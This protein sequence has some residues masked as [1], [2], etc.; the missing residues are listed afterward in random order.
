M[1]KILACLSVILFYGF[2]F[3]QDPAAFDYFKEGDAALNRQQYAQALAYF[4]NAIETDG[5][6]PVYLNAKSLA[7]TSM[8]DYNGAIELNT[9]ALELAPENIPTLISR[10]VNYVLVGQF[11]K[12]RADLD[13]A[14]PY[15]S[16][17]P[18]YYVALGIFN[19]ALNNDSQAKQNY[20]QAKKLGI[21]ETET[22]YSRL[23]VLR[24]IGQRTKALSGYNELI[25][26]NRNDINAYL[27]RAR[28]QSQLG[29]IDN[30]ISDYNYVLAVSSA[31]CDA[32]TWK[33]KLSNKPSLTAEERNTLNSVI[34]DNTCSDES[35]AFAYYKLYIADKK[36]SHLLRAVSLLPSELEFRR[37]YLNYLKLNKEY[38]KALDVI[39]RMILSEPD[40]DALL[41]ERAQIY[42]N[43]G[44]YKEAFDD[45]TRMLDSGNSA[46]ETYMLAADSAYQLN[47]LTNALA[48]Y[49]LADITLPTEDTAVA[50]GY[51]WIIYT[52]YSQADSEFQRA[53]KINSRNVE[54]I[55]GRATVMLYQ[56]KWRPALREIQKSM[57]YQTNYPENYIVLAAHTYHTTKSVKRTL[58][59][60]QTAADM[61]YKG[62][63]SLRSDNSVWGPL[64]EDFRKNRA[65]NALINEQTSKQ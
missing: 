43:G 17:Y 7:L 4:D 15:A 58:A 47:D 38:D 9:K 63:E 22:A 36:T 44:Y 46:Y 29:M 13:N 6:N 12:A 50:L 52:K 41:M 5:A 51:I 61:G 55:L 62:F 65:F 54:A 59:D 31:N 64:F 48:N 49:T 3:A 39:N 21:D 33:I 28:T 42:F 37:D 1:K 34:N 40:N 18:Q 24:R 57:Q 19:D 14:A 20:E 30:A 27:G 56:K 32:R 8:G 60:L 25:G 2:A 53:L 35:H 26:R 23:R 10:S 16:E 11:D 45:A